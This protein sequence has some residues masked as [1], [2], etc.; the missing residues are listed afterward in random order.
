MLYITAEEILVMHS[1][2]ID[3][4]G[5]LHGVRDNNLLSSSAERPRTSYGGHEL[6]KTV[7]EKAGALLHSLAM[8][9][10]FMDGNKRT[11]IVSTARFLYVNGY[12]LTASNKE[13][14]NF[15]VNVVTE[16]YEVTTIAKWIKGHSKKIR[17]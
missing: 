3:E 8:N 4:T 10:V 7:F 15:M 1:E 9:H 2:I 17:K 6:Y 5:G 11:A 16:K 12:D 13:I 14:E